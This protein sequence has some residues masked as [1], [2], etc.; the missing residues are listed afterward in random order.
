MTDTIFSE[1]NG[2]TD[3]P[4]VQWINAS[5]ALDVLTGVYGVRPTVK[6]WI[7]DMLRDGKLTGRAAAV[8]ISSLS[9]LSFSV[10]GDDVEVEHGVIIPASYWRTSSKSWEA[11]QLYWRWPNSEAVVTIRADLHRR[12]IF[13]GLQFLKADIDRLAHMPG[14]LPKG[15]RRGPKTRA[16]DWGSVAAAVCRLA[17]LGVFVGPPPT[18]NNL[19]NQLDDMTDGIFGDTSLREFS[20]AFLREYQRPIIGNA[21]N[22]SPAMPLS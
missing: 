8:W 1:S 22:R 13:K 10:P 7:A 9:K 6:A 21:G 3:E 20:T 19:A 18:A 14:A 4:Q 16:G 17:E 11:D 15:E 12:R 5:V 2:N